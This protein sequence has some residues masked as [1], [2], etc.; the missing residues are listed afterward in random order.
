PS[1][2]LRPSLLF[3]EGDDFFHRLVFSLAFPIVP[4]PGDGKARF[5]PLHVDDLAAALLA[6]ASR[7]LAE[8][9]GVHEVGGPEPITYDD[10]LAETMR[11]TGKR[12]PTLHLPVI[13][14]K[15]PAIVMGL[16]MPDPPV[17]EH[18]LDLLAVDNTPRDNALER[19]FGVRPRPFR[20]AL[21]YLRPE[22]LRPVGDDRADDE[23]RRADAQADRSAEP[24][25]GERA[26][27]RF[28]ERG[29]ERPDHP[30]PE[31]QAVEPA[32]HAGQRSAAAEP[33]PL[34]DPVADDH[35]ADGD[36]KHQE[37]EVDVHRR[38]SLD[39]SPR[40]GP[41]SRKRRVAGESSACQAGRRKARKGTD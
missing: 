20:G 18:Q 1:V 22:A 15:P 2:V 34:Q 38:S 9:R 10:L 24:E 23:D 32:R 36:A 14:M 5:Q 3:G 27:D 26:A 16:V 8:V 7:P 37:R 12:R 13:L 21:G 40:G 33:A 11:G 6:A 29:N 17:T 30:W 35:D 28:G 31:P 19:V 25:D 4:V 41:R 39:D